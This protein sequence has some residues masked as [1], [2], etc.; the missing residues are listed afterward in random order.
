MFV[1]VTHT[2]DVYRLVR[3]GATETYGVTPVITGLGMGITPAGT[4]LLVAYPDLP[5]YAAYDGYY[6]DSSVSFKIGDKLTDGITSWIV[7][8]TPEIYS[9]PF[10]WAAHLALEVVV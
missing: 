3:T 10:G 1:I 6:E 8:G 5:A 7:R 4:D 9:S 2:V